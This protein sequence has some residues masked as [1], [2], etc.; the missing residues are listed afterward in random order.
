M[1]VFGIKCICLTK[2]TVQL[3][4]FYFFYDTNIQKVQQ[5]LRMLIKIEQAFKILQMKRYI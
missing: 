5:Y 4:Q 1:A 3:L 2:V